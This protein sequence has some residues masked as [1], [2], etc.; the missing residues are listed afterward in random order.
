VASALIHLVE[1]HAGLLRAI[2]GVQ[3]SGEWTTQDDVVTCPMCQAFALEA[4]CAES[5]TALSLVGIDD[6]W[7]GMRRPAAS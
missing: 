6:Q 1:L 4:V 5:V 2:C 3:R 7:L